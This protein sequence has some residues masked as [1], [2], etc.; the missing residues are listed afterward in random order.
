M[1]GARVLPPVLGRLLNATFWLA[2]RVPLQILLTLWTTRLI[3]EAI[4]A[5][6]SGAYGFAWNFGF[7][8]FLFEFG[9]SSALQRKISD[10]YTRDDRDGVKSRHR[11]RYELL[12]GGRDSPGPR[13]YWPS[14][15]SRSLTLSSRARAPRT[16]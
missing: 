10:A 11:Q 2:I 1:P 15:T 9:A 5:D 16:I 12:R 14:P 4:G 13:H 7:L 8:Q 6:Q 3:L